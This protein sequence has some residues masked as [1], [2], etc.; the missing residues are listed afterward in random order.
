MQRKVA[1]VFLYKNGIRERSV[2]IVRRYGTA[3]QPEVALELFGEE[4][5]RKQWRVYY[6]TEGE[7][8]LEA[9]YLWGSTTERGRSEARLSQCRLCAEAG[10]GAGVVL[11]PERAGDLKHNGG[12]NRTEQ[13]GGGCG[14]QLS[15]P[16]LREYLCA[17]YDEKELTEAALREAFLR[18]PEPS[19]DPRV[20][21]A[22]KLMEEITKAAGGEAASEAAASVQQ[23]MYVESRKARRQIAYLEK[24]LLLNPPYGPCRRFDVEYSVRVT[25]EELAGFPKEGKRFAENS[26]VLHGYYRYRHVLLGRRR[27]KNAEDYVLLV[28]GIYNEKEAKLAELF[29]FPEF[30]P[31]VQTKSEADGAASGKELFGY[32]CRKI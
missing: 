6:F 1:Y 23:D 9:A 8:L 12:K 22:K 17:R 15:H 30:L 2:G 16:D 32:Y 26:F 27:K 19:C 31:L 4:E 28:P 5:R 11:L 14:R 3:E 24:L 21:S 13:S 7:A 10:M 25:P 29:G 20:E 18:K